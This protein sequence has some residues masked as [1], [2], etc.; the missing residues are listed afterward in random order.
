MVSFQRFW[1][2]FN[3]HKSINK[4]KDKNHV[5]ISIDAEK[6]TDRNLRSIMVKARGLYE[7]K[8][9]ISTSWRLFVTNL[10]PASY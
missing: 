9:H 7:Q 1:V 8:E 6:V 4:F 2:Q 3:T 5:I 10:E